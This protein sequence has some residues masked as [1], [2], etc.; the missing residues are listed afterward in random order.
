LGLLT[1]IVK[2]RLDAS[3]PESFSHTQQR[4]A[5]ESQLSCCVAGNFGKAKH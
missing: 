3:S 5:V 2:D 4:A 1:V